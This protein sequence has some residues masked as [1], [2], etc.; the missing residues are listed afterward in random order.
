MILHMIFYEGPIEEECEYAAPM[1]DL[2]PVHTESGE[3]P[4]PALAAVSQIGEQ[5]VRCAHGLTGLRFPIVMSKYDVVSL[6]RMFDHFDQTRT[7]V[8]RISHSSRDVLHAGVESCA[9][10]QHVVPSPKR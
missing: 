1:R 2:G 8:Q 3:L 5:D 7:R 6:R 4:L 10:G 9:R